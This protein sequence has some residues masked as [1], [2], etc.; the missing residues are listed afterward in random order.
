[1]KKIT[2]LTLAV[3]LAMT[4]ARTPALFSQGLLFEPDSIDFGRVPVGLAG[5][6]D[7]YHEFRVTNQSNHDLALQVR[8]V[9]LAHPESFGLFSPETAEIHPILRRIYDA[10]G[11][12]R[13]D[14]NEDPSELYELFGLGY[15]HVDE[16]ILWR[17]HFSIIGQDPMTQITAT[18]AAY[19]NSILFDIQ[20]GKF[21]GRYRNEVEPLID[22]ELNPGQSRSF[23]LNYSPPEP[24]DV[25]GWISLVAGDQQ[26]RL[27]V[28]G[29]GYY[30]EALELST[31]RIDFGDAYTGRRIRRNLQVTNTAGVINYVDF[32]V[33]N[34]EQFYVYDSDVAG[35]HDY[36]LA[37]FE[38]CK[39]YRQQYGEDPS[40]VEELID[41][42][43]LRISEDLARQWSFTLIGQDPISQIEAVST[44]EFHRGAGHVVMLDIGTDTFNGFG[45]YNNVDNDYSFL[46]TGRSST[47]KV[48]FKPDDFG[49]IEG[50]LRVRSY[51]RDDWQAFQ[52]YE[53]TLRGN[54]LSVENPDPAA[55]PAS[56]IL[57]PPF[58]SPFNSTAILSFQTPFNEQL[59]ATLMDMSG[60][61]W[62]KWTAMQAAPGEGRLVIDGTGLSA[63]TYWLQVRQ[64]GNVAAQRVTLVR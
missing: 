2:S 56:I 63:G 11:C 44:G 14:Y 21:T 40:S 53:V 42:D 22:F 33:S 7:S 4:I 62:T 41:L 24:E 39:S 1:M 10:V 28:S 26:S 61:E 55:L 5:L 45:F 35:A 59:E 19:N 57:N 9:N 16:G 3:T 54:G 34:P 52:D 23:M 20:T 18:T 58:P 36:I 17:W 60:R 32:E 29:S 15:L 38:G 6:P 49:Q 37:I 8:T 31:N 30:N 43:L 47:F 12:Y 48:G 64:G 46:G 27:Y 25:E 51:F 13:Q 50:T